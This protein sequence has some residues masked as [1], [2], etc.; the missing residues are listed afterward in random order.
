MKRVLSFLFAFFILS[1]GPAS[2][3]EP[4]EKSGYEKFDE[5]FAE[6]VVTP[7]YRVLFWDLVFWDNKLP[8]GEGVGTVIDGGTVTAWDAGSGTYTL[9]TESPVPRSSVIAAPAE[10]VTQTFGKLEVAISSGPKGLRGQIQARTLDPVAE[11]IPVTADG[12]PGGQALA[13]WIGPA[14]DLG[15]LSAT[16]TDLWVVKGLAPFAA[17]VLVKDGLWEVASVGIDLADDALPIAVGGRVRSGDLLGEVTALDGDQVTIRSEATTTHEGR[18]ANPGALSAP[19]VVVWLI[20]GA[21]FFTLRM[22]FINLRGF[23][24]SIQVTSGK[25]DDPDDPGE[26][27]HFQALSAALSATVGLGNIAGVAV[28]VGVGGPGAIFWMIC[29]GF[30]GMSSKFVECT[31]GQMYRIEDE[32][33]NIRG[34]PMQ[35]LSNGLAEYGMGGLGK[36]LAVVFAVMCIGGSLGGGNMFQ[37]NQSFAAVK[38]I[39]PL[40]ETYPIAYGLILAFCVGLVIIG[41][42]RRIGAAASKIVPLMCGIYVLAAAYILLVNA[43]HIPDAFAK[44]IGEAFSPEAGRGGLVGVL[45]IGFQRA[46]FS[47]EAGVG[48]AAIAHSAASTDEP[49]REGIVA[50]MGPFID[51]LIVCTM[52]GLVVVITGAYIEL[53]NEGAVMTSWAFEQPLSWFPLLLATATVMF[54]FSTMISWSYY[55]E[56]CWTYLFGPRNSMIYKVGFVLCVVI[57]S[58]ISLGSVLDFSDLMILGMAFPNI[59]GLVVLS[60]KVRRALDDYWSRYRAGDFDVPKKAA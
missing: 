47:N 10:P 21:V 4:N 20:I 60:S 42:I 34:G 28:A 32:L 57:G 58:V 38:E 26:V 44:I 45:I 8:E 54:A 1:F 3:A 51:T 24:H 55:G 36:V 22:S 50:L 17:V 40:F 5:A 30:L 52:T 18:L 14:F 23:G 39:V 31:L 9:Q 35:Y 41:G 37:A 53:P 15:D 2:A 13:D 6:W 11:D 49:V 12:A 33:G 29:A 56:R 27:T 19:I 16:D 48:S 7:F 46:A 43:Q 25:F 59:F